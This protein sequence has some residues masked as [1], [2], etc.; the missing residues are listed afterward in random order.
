MNKITET[1]KRILRGLQNE[2]TYEDVLRENAIKLVNH[3]KKYCKGKNCD[4]SLFLL[5]ELLRGKYKIELT[6]EEEKI[7][8]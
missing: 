1:K 6:E 3:H 2:K 4:I 7:F 5:R 8:V